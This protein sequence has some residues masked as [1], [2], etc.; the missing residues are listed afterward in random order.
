MRSQRIGKMLFLTTD[1]SRA[2]QVP[3]SSPSFSGHITELN[4]AE[5][6]R[7]QI[8]EIIN[9]QDRT[10]WELVDRKLSNPRTQ[11][12]DA[13]SLDVLMHCIDMGMETASEA[14]DKDIV[15]VVG[16]TGAGKSTFVNILHGCSMKQ[17]WDH[18]KKVSNNNENQA[19]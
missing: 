19:R 10:K 11:L 18:G 15:M 3:L 4:K 2:P 5:R 8:P 7:S 13:E 6:P 12:T 17:Y 14:N 16:N 1:R 9:E